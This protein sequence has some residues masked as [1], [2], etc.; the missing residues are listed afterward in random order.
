MKGRARLRST[1]SH[2][3]GARNYALRR[4][5]NANLCA[6]RGLEALGREV[7]L[8]SSEREY[9]G[10]LCF[11]N[12]SVADEYFGVKSVPIDSAIPHNSANS[13][14]PQS[15]RPLRPEARQVPQPRHRSGSPV[16]VF[17][18]GSAAVLETCIICMD[19]A[20]DSTLLPCR[21]TSLCAHCAGLLEICPL[22]RCKI[23][24]VVPRNM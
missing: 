15:T 1:P 24:L 3:S 20:G 16:A 4:L 17:N 7:A 19:R 8:H 23:V 12:L 22:C 2:C 6:G 11:P 9:Y 13:S 18:D 10:A 21:H 14:M 5:G